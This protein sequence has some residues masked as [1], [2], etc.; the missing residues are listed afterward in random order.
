MHST[1]IHIKVFPCVCG[2]HHRGI[3]TCHRRRRAATAYLLI[4]S[5]TNSRIYIFSQIQFPNISDDI[6]L[7]TLRACFRQVVQI[8]ICG[9]KFPSGRTHCVAKRLKAILDSEFYMRTKH[10]RPPRRDAAFNLMD[11]IFFLRILFI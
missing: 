3:S 2:V 7:S 10:L 11:A 8:F 5:H 1:Y 9:R 4:F 6:Y